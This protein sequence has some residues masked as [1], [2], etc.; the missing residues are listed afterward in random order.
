MS[1]T[2]RA[3]RARR[4][5]IKHTEFRSAPRQSRTTAS[6][7]DRRAKRYLARMP[8]EAVELTSPGTR[9]SGG[10]IWEDPN[11]D[12]RSNLEAQAVYSEMERTDGVISGTLLLIDETLRSARLEVEPANDSQIAG[13]MA[14]HC[15]WGLN[16]GR[17]RRPRG[18]L[19]SEMIR[20]L[21][22]FAAR[23]FAYAEIIPKTIRP[24]SGEF[25]GDRVVLDR[26]AYCEQSAHDEWVLD[27]EGR[28]LRGITQLPAFGYDAPLQ[29][30]KGTPMH[31]GRPLVG[32]E[33][34]V[35]LAFQGYGHNFA[36][37]AL[38]RRA[39]FPWRAKNS[40]LDSG[41][42]A[43]DRFGSP[44]PTVE[45]DRRLAYEQGYSKT[46]VD[47]AVEDA[48]AN[49]EAYRV[50][51]DGHFMSIPGITYGTF[52][53]GKI[54]SRHVVDFVKLQNREILLGML[55]QFVSLGIGDVGSRS[56]GTI[57]RSVHARF[58]ANL[59]DQIVKAITTQV[60]YPI[61]CWQFGIAAANDHAPR[62]VHH[63]IDS[64][65]LAEV[66][67]LLPG[68]FQVGILKRTQAFENELLRVLAGAE[69]AGALIRASED[70]PEEARD[71][72]SGGGGV[73]KPGPGRP[74]EEG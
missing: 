28:E 2:D 19:L 64:A 26:L 18:Q 9:I 42:V 72:Q 11:P 45:I 62:L 57:H 4:K 59:M 7:T 43:I 34:L 51:R 16:V 56:V 48:I 27:K 1:T 15:R 74:Q 46:Q 22:S 14:A 20:P 30:P 41:V 52:G 49:L 5:R 54:D 40:A 53:E 35:R 33:R 73:F 31:H 63:D 8:G 25:R 67:G 17:K 69:S 3:Q 12:M 58:V 68:L 70:M 61:C 32:D 38:L 36:G 29:V 37:I 47:Q 50:E 10:R 24:T 13:R 23:G 65:M 55:A 21:Q 44:T 66:L 39:L 60:M 71:D 6:S